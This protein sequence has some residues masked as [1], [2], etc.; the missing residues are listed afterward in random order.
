MSEF[1]ALMVSGLG[2]QLGASDATVS[3]APLTDR[4]RFPLFDPWVRVPERAPTPAP[5]TQVLARSLRRQTGWSQRKLASVLRSTHPTVRALEEGRSS[6]QQDELYDQIVGVH[7]VV[8]RVF[9]VADRDSRETNRLLSA[10]TAR[11]TSAIDLLTA[12]DFAGAYLAAL[13]AARP[14]RTTRMMQGFWRS[15]PG[16]A[17]RSLEAADSH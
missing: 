5:R 11:A 9:E 10:T 1:Q 3:F 14:R 4:F 13:D 15:T 6:A 7:E 8:D 12:G 17:T 16:T 2:A